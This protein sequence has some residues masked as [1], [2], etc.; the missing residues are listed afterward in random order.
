[1]ANYSYIYNWINYRVVVTMVNIELD[2]QLI[3]EEDDMTL[4]NVS[5]RGLIL[6]TLAIDKDKVY[7]FT[8]CKKII[9]S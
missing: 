1:M 6:G 7:D 4:W 5:S 8:K 9:L 2:L 3:E